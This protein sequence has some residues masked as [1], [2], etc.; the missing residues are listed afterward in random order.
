[1]SLIRATDDDD[2]EEADEADEGV[3]EFNCALVKLFGDIE[4]DIT[5]SLLD[6]LTLFCLLELKFVW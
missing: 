4:V 1:M 5:S 3:G 2:V 6:P